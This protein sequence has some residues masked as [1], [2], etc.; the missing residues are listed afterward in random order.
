MKTLSAILILTTLTL[1]TSCYHKPS[2]EE[3]LK[4]D[5]MRH[6][7]MNAICKDH[8]MATEMVNTLTSSPASR[9]MMRGSCE[10]MRT[11]MA[12]DMIKK[13]TS[14][15]NLIIS[16]LL[17]LVN[18]DSE[19]CDKTCVQLSNN[20]QIYRILQKDIENNGKK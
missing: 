13:D 8:S 17:F 18:R 12:N 7:I 6:D 9:D 19:M 4:D 20:P 14:M 10:F 16:N 15:Q 1:F 2:A 11:V 5:N 3:L